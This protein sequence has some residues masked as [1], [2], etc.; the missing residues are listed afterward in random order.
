MECSPSQIQI[1]QLLAQE[2]WLT[3]EQIVRWQQR[4][5]SRV[6]ADLNCLLRAKLVQRVNPRSGWI[7][8]RAVF[9]LTDRGVDALASQQ[10]ADTSGYRRINGISRAR[11]TVLLWRLER[12]WNVRNLMLSLDTPEYHVKSLK[13]EVDEYY[14]VKERHGII[15]VHGRGML[16]HED[17]WFL[18]FVVEWD[19][20]NE[21]V[22]PKRLARFS[23]WLKDARFHAFGFKKN[24]PTLLIVAADA[25]RWHEI[26]DG[27]AGAPREYGAVA[28][29]MYLTTAHLLRTRGANAGIWFSS[30][31]HERG[32]VFA[33][34]R[35]QEREPKVLVS[36][37]PSRVSKIG[38]FQENPMVWNGN[39]TAAHLLQWKLSL[40]PVAKRAFHW[41]LRYS[42]LSVDEI[43]WLGDE[44]QWRVQ[45]ELKTL[46][47]KG[48]VTSEEF[49]GTRYFVITPNGW[50]YATAEAGHGRALRRFM[51][52]RGSV[53]NVRRLVFH[54][55]H[56]RA[57]NVFF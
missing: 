48:L 20:W 38:T 50:R 29:P 30:D 17:G 43:A 10:N 2:P 24:L 54:F 46:A 28:P 57:T 26:W 6:Q 37:P 1:L 55:A 53:R 31:M 35:W 19:A 18:P 52:R 12:M 40:S 7:P 44:T 47:E 25:W 22:D 8:A 36:T 13:T 3:P 11:H 4:G 16:A 34:A 56:T 9:G 5:A 27:Y 41:V 51:K 42:L 14:A 23:R 21:P 49:E 45:K 39:R 32:Q 33:S 15:H